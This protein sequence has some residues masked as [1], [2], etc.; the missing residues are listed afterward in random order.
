[1]SGPGVLLLVTVV[2]IVLALVYFLVSTIL[3]LRQIADG[4]DDAIAGVVEILEK[5]KPV[6]PVVADINANLDAAVA[7]LEGL[8]VKKAGMRDAMGLIEGLY[9][10][11]AARGPARLPRL[12]DHEGAAHQRGL[13]ARDADARAAGPRGADRRRQQPG[14]PGAAQRPRRLAGRAGAVPRASARRARRSSARTRPTSTSPRRSPDADPRTGR[15]HAGVLDR[16]RPARAGRAQDARVVAGGHSLIPMMK[17][18]LADPE[19]LIDIN[20]LTELAYIREEETA[21]SASAR[22]PA[23]STCSGPSCCGSASRCSG[24]PRT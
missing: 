5:T 18:R 9:P 6:E 17:L 1:M 8:L 3:A 14:R 10:G 12:G 16:G 23:T 24:T 19:R 21:R 22:S 11:A 15:I 2:L 7:A 4:L 13:H 20:D